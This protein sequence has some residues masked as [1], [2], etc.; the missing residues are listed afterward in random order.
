M[1]STQWQSFLK[2]CLDILRNGYSKYDGLQAINEFILL[3]TLKLVENRICDIDINSNK[4]LH[5]NKKTDDTQICIGLDCQ[6]TYL[7][8]NFCSKEKGNNT[9]AKSKE[10]FDLLYNFNR[11]WDIENELDDD[12]KHISQIRK[13]NNKI[14]CVIHRFNMYTSNLCK[15]TDDVK[16]TITTF[17]KTHSIDVQK[18]VTKIQETFQQIDI[19]H[20]NYDA[21]GDAYEKMLADELGNQSKRNGQ[22]FTKRNLIEIIINELNIKEDDICYDPACGTGGFLLGFANKFN[23]N[24]TFV[25]N[26]IYGQEYLADV[27]KTLD[28]NMIANNYDGAIQNISKGDSIRDHNYHNKIKNKFSV[29]GA[30]PPFGLS[31]ENPPKEYPIKKL[32]SVALFLQ[33]IYFSLKDGGRAGIVIDRGILNNGTDKLKAWE[34]DLR[35][36][37]IEKTSITKIINLPTGIFKHTNFATSIIFFTKGIKTEKIKYIEGYFKDE[38]KGT[39]EKTLYLG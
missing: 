32:N 18:L 36:F 16:N 10:L 22:Y 39:S 34:R 38:D 24:K 1:D 3:I 15:L 17:N 6:F 28:F 13:K 4:I 35:K 20:F 19:K 5:K 14:E 25:N 27:C 9:I 12:C 8:D 33:H 23:G 29:I 2:G 7:Y 31:I 21:F 30:N 26:N 11:D 37:L